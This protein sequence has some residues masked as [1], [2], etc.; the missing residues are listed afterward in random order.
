[1]RRDRDAIR[2]AAEFECDVY[3]GAILWEAFS[4]ADRLGEHFRD[5]PAFKKHMVPLLKEPAVR[6]LRAGL[7]AR[8]RNQAVYHHDDAVIPAGLE[9]VGDGATVLLSATGTTR[10]DLYYD[11]AD[12]AVMQFALGGSADVEHFAERGTA[13]LNAIVATALR[14]AAAADHLI[15]EYAQRTG[16]RLRSGPRTPPL[17]DIR[18]RATPSTRTEQRGLV[19]HLKPAPSSTQSDRSEPER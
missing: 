16:W 4:F 3:L 1:M 10:R 8:L 9:L 5:S 11:L 2:D 12:I 18:S 15:K 6:E 13:A 19:V 17:L 7:L 14:F